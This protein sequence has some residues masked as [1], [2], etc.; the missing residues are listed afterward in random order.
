LMYQAFLGLGRYD[1]ALAQLERLK[2]YEA[3][4]HP[5]LDRAELLLRLG[6]VDEAR[7]AAERVA[8]DQTRLI[9]EAKATNQPILR[10]YFRLA[11]ALEILGRQA[12]AVEQLDKFAQ[13][14]S[15]PIPYPDT[16]VFRNNAAALDRLAKI[17]EKAGLIGKR[18]LEIEKS[19]S[20]PATNSTL[21]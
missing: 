13:L 5:E 14:E 8:S 6:R 17:H 12:E 10:G 4:L 9:D 3:R 11:V 20:S 19:Y 15:F 1:E 21:R 18:I 2:P 7:Q 16:W